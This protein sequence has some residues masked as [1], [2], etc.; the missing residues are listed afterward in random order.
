MTTIRR[1]KSS[2]GIYPHLFSYLLPQINLLIHKNC[3]SLSKEPSTFLLFPR[4]ADPSLASNALGL[5]LSNQRLWRFKVHVSTTAASR[6]QFVTCTK[7][8]SSSSRILFRTSILI[9]STRRWWTMLSHYW[10]EVN[11]AH[12]ITKRKHST[13]SPA[14]VRVFQFASLY[15]SGFSSN[16][17]NY[18]LTHSRRS[19]CYPIYHGCAWPST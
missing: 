1:E 14:S 17:K 12:S 13:R 10:L 11:R 8:G 2:W 5:V 9:R 4:G 18:R 6:R 7:M 16:G 3:S 19:N 15:Q